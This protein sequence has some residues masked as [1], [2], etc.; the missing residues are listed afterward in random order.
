MKVV[1]SGTWMYDGTY[2][3]PVYIVRLSYDFWYAIGEANGDL[4]ADE[5]PELNSEGHLYY[6]GFHDPAQRDGFWADSPG[7]HTIAE[8]KTNAESRLPSAVSWQ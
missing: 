6:V 4:E 5:V 8:A 2:Q 7:F 3:E 1:A